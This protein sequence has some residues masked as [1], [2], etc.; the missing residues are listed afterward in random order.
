M[1]INEQLFRDIA[2]AIENRPERYKQG[3]WLAMPEE[4]ADPYSYQRYNDLEE[5]PSVEKVRKGQFNCGAVGCVAGHAVV[6]S[7]IP[8]TDHV[9]D[10]PEGSFYFGK[11]DIADAGQAALGISGYLAEWLFDGQRYEPSMPAVLRAIA[12]GETDL[13][14]LERIEFERHQRDNA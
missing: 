13:D 8:L 2:E 14:S 9:F 6:L 4:P 1:P 12:D 10:V 7:G 11:V 5:V 3:F